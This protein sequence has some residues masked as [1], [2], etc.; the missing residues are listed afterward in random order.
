M[1]SG[2]ACPRGPTYAG[3]GLTTPGR[4]LQQQNRLK[5]EDL[6]RQLE[7]ARRL[8]Q[9]EAERLQRRTEAEKADLKATISRLEVDVMKVGRLLNLAE[10]SDEYWGLTALG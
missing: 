8:A 7:T 6:G 4:R 9:S 3:E 1:R 5:E 10:I 2:K